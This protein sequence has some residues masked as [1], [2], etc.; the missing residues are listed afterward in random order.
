MKILRKIKIEGKNWNDIFCLPCV[1]CLGKD[2]DDN[3]RPYV[4]LRTDAFD[5]EQSIGIAWVGDTLVE[6]ENH[7]W[8]IEEGPKN[9]NQQEG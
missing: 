4:S 5:W 9:G 1:E 2:L 3:E 7:K 8:R 6:M